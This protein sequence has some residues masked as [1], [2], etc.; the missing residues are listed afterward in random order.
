MSLE[1]FSPHIFRNR[2][3]CCL[4]NISSQPALAQKSSFPVIMQYKNFALALKISD[5]IV[6]LWFLCCI[7]HV[8]YTASPTS[9]C[10]AFLI[11]FFLP[12]ITYQL[13]NWFKM[14]FNNRAKLRRQMDRESKDQQVG[15]ISYDLQSVF[16]LPRAYISNF[17][18]KRNYQFITYCSLWYESQSGRSGNDISSGLIKMFRRCKW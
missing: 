9:G 1:I 15:I 6:I 2:I 10:S 16:T 14:G 7:N 8:V 5:E 3:S 4:L 13:K 12:K 11:T 17:Y 18:Y